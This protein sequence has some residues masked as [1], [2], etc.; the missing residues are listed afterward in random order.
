M[1]SLKEEGLRVFTMMMGEGLAVKVTPKSK[2]PAE[3]LPG[4]EWF[5]VVE[6]LNGS[7]E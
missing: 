4:G 5:P 2:H 1:G 3:Y 7:L 6:R